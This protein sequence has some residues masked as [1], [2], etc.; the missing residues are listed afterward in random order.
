MDFKKILKTLCEADGVKETD[1]LETYDDE[2]IPEEDPTGEL[3]IESDEDAEPVTV[4]SQVIVIDASVY[5]AEELGME[6]DDFEN[7][8]TK[9]DANEPAIV[10]DEDDDNPELIDIVYE[11]GLEVFNLPKTN[12]ELFTPEEIEPVEPIETDLGYLDG[13]E[14]DNRGKSDW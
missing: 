11:D 4:G 10:F 9:A 5:T 13:E 6:H 3:P 14:I 2:M 8:I 12:V 1:E 7:F